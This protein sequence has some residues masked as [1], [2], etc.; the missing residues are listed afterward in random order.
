[1]TVRITRDEGLQ[2]RITLRVEGRLTRSGAESLDE[3]CAV[4]PDAF[5]INL[6][7][8]DFLDLDAA[9]VLRGLARR[10]ARLEAANYFVREVL[11]A[12]T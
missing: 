7:G 10:G 1:M 6:M 2:G 8:V 9:L 3:M 12:G 5:S 11:G 4:N